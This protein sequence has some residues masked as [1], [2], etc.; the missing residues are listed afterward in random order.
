MNK[1][2]QVMIVGGGIA[3]LVLALSLHQIGVS[4]RV[5]ESVSELK[6]L[7]AGI[8]LLPHAVRELDELGLIP[9]LDAVAIR[10]KDASYFNHHGQLI[11]REVAGQAASPGRRFFVEK[12]GLLEEPF[13]NV[14]S[15]PD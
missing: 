4:C 14:W 13:V 9:A 2:T 7:G 10:T 15:E 5:Y 8:N 11:Y 6:P 3:G 12:E 1:D